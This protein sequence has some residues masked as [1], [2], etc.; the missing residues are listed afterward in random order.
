MLPRESNIYPELIGAFVALSQRVVA[1]ATPTNAL[2]PAQ[3]LV[4]S[5]LAANQSSPTT[6]GSTALWATTGGYGGFARAPC[7]APDGLTSLRHAP[8]AGEFDL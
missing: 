6:L 5:P 4:K 2:A 7:A 3:P 8:V 1:L